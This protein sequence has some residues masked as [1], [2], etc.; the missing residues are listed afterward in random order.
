MVAANRAKTSMF[1]LFLALLL[2]HSADA[3][4]YEQ[5]VWDDL[6]KK[7]EVFLR[8]LR[9]RPLDLPPAGKV[10]QKIAC[11]FD[12]K[13]TYGV[14][15][16][17]NYDHRKPWPVV[18]FNG[19]TGNGWQYCMMYQQ[20]AEQLGWILV[21][22][23]ESKNGPLPEPIDNNICMIKDVLARF[24]VHKEMCIGAGFGGGGR[25]AGMLAFAEKDYPWMMGAI[26]MGAAQGPLPPVGGKQ[27][28]LIVGKLDPN[29]SEVQAWEKACRKA[30]CKVE[31]I[32]WNAGH[33]MPSGPMFFQA[34]KWQTDQFLKHSTDTSDATQNKRQDYV[35]SL[36]DVARR[37]DAG[38]KVVEIYA[39]YR[40]AYEAGTTIPCGLKMTK[41]AL[42]L[43][44]R[45]NDLA[46]YPEVKKEID[47][48]TELLALIERVERK[49]ANKA[50]KAEEIKQ[51]AVAEPTPVV[52]APA[53]AVQAPAV[54]V[55]PATPD[56]PAPT[57]AA[58]ETQAPA[59]APTP[60]PAAVTPATPDT[61]DTP[62]PSSPV[63]PEPAAPDAQAGAPTRP[64]V[65]PVPAPTPA[66]EAAPVPAP[67]AETATVPVPV[68]PA[69]GLEPTP[70]QTPA[71]APAPAPVP[72]FDP[73][74]PMAQIAP[75][76]PA[77]NTKP[78]AG[79]DDDDELIPE[80]DDLLPEEL[81]RRKQAAKAE[82]DAA[83]AKLAAEAKA[84]E[85]A[86]KKAAEEAR[87][88]AISPWEQA[89]SLAKKYPGT[90]SAQRAQQ[91][92]MEWQ[93]RFTALKINKAQVGMFGVPLPPA[94]ELSSGRL[95]PESA[96]TK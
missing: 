68:T 2:V 26:Q 5:S 74:T 15:L 79:V 36:I 9:T 31:T 55:A 92:A 71:P 76:L 11:Y 63:I 45:M 22:A 16:P 43:E 51:P 8:T 37:G 59:P 14:Y 41:Q 49:E 84:V 62:A 81:E 66:P 70:A 54:P 27:I 10:T 24:N 73:A 82:T 85:E 67:P 30:D 3:R 19:P 48:Y 40:D 95:Q 91:L 29:L 4:A 17:K 83:A 46:R 60:A 78:P 89:Q 18:F 25:I 65:A 12:A 44:R 75:T 38:N 94:E 28:Y 23:N 42:A 88:A 35:Q 61:P 90:P 33:Q 13:Y 50:L 34:L 1:A 80:D 64:E 77:A 87:L 53:P 21:G 93:L 39:R 47:C 7:E 6:S 86:K 96:K 20:Y 52:Q 56:I 69:P 32:E 57:P 72:A 58:P